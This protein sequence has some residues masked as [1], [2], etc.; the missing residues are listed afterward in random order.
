MQMRTAEEPLPLRKGGQLKKEHVEP[1]F[2]ERLRCFTDDLSEK[3]LC[4]DGHGRALKVRI[5]PRKGSMQESAMKS[6]T[7]P[8]TAFT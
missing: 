8:L 4:Q 7:N 3:P 2:P 6:R 5:H 1:G